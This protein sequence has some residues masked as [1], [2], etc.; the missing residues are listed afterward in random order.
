MLMLYLCAALRVKA[1]PVG[2]QKF[3]RGGVNIYQKC[4]KDARRKK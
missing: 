1:A 2:A 4:G 3:S